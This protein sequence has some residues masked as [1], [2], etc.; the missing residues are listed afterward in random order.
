[1]TDTDSKIT[2]RELQGLGFELK[3][4]F[5]HDQF[6]TNRYVKGIL[7]MEFTYEDDLLVSSD[8]TIEEINCMQIS[9]DEV[10]QL[11][12]ILNE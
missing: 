10:K 3:K 11:D 1:M 9:L 6:I 12:K 5:E 2:E 4:S 7:Q 8:I